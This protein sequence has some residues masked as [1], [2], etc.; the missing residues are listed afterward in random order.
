[1]ED[2]SISELI[3]WATHSEEFPVEKRKGVNDMYPVGTWVKV[4][5]HD[6]AGWIG[7]I[8]KSSRYT[9]QHMVQITLDDNGNRIGPNVKMQLAL[10]DYEVYKTDL[11][12]G[13]DTSF[14][15]DLALDTLD[16]D[17]FN[18]IIK[19]GNDDVITR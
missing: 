7:F 9:N 8:E 4:A 16:N 11:E 14:L 18:E 3:Y 2:L 1:M 6:Y 12:A 5:R 15:V 17:W 13:Y 19:G 10:Y